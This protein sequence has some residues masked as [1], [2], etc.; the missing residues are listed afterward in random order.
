MAT[1][2]QLSEAE[3]QLSP[4]NAELRLPADLEGGNLRIGQLR[5]HHL[6]Q[7]GSDRAHVDLTQA[8]PLATPFP[9]TRKV[10]RISGRAGK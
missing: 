4:E 2:P 6:C 8:A 5:P 10:E 9:I 7:R 1:H 3:A